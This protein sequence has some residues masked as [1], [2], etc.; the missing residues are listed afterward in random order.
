MT[1]LTGFH[2]TKELEMREATET[3]SSASFVDIY[4]KFYTNGQVFTR[5]MT[6]ET[7]SIFSIINVLHLDNSNIPTTPANEVYFSHNLIKIRSPRLPPISYQLFTS[8]QVG[9]TRRKQVGGGT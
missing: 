8:R 1:L 2:T 9:D 7:T 6:R 3:A 4:L 5:S